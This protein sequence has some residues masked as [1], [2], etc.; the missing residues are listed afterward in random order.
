[1]PVIFLFALTSGSPRRPLSLWPLAFGFALA[2]APT[3]VVEQERV[4]TR[5]FQQVVGGYSEVV[6]GSTGERNLNNIEINLL[7]YN[8]TVHSYVYGPLLDPVSGTLAALGIA[9]ALGNLRDPGRRLLVI[10]FA[11]AMFMTGILS[12]Y[13][14][15]AITRLI[16]AVPPL[17]LLAGLLV[18]RFGGLIPLTQAKTPERLRTI[19]GV[20]IC[21]TV[22]PVI[23]VLNL[24]QFW[25]ITPSVFA[26]SPE[27][28]A[29]GAFRSEGCGGD[30]NG[31]LF[32]GNAVAEGSLF[33]RVISSLHP[34][35]PA[36]GGITHSRIA[37]G[38]GLP[39]PPPRCVVFLNSDAAEARRLQNELARQY[40]DGRLMPFANPSGTT[41][42]EV[43]TR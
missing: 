22:L 39:E 30:L 42:V 24:W 16:F 31:S 13:P 33:Q 37:E 40:P 6:T 17:A 2:V 12:P 25:H 18:G 28:V 14:H 34:E 1:M 29:L 21:A 3:F 38:A 11:V 9:F 35:G 20:S 32:V 4:F 10:W 19:A 27:A 5:M 41:T 7:N 15:V 43:F 8:S 23:L 36:L 26:H